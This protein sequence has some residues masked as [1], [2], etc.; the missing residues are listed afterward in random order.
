MWAMGEPSGSHREGDHVHRAALHRPAEQVGEDRLHLGRV[1]PVVGGS[2]IDLVG[3]ADVG[4]VLDPGYVAGIGVRPVAV[5]PLGVAQPGEGAGVDEFLAEPVVLL[6]RAVAPLDAVRRRQGGDLV[7]PGEELGVLGGRGTSI[8]LQSLSQLRPTG[9]AGPVAGGGS[10]GVPMSTSE[11]SRRRVARP[12]ASRSNTTRCPCRSI[13]KIEPARASA[14]RS[15]S[16][17]SVSRITTPAPVSGSYDL[18]TPCKVHLPCYSFKGPWTLPEAVSWRAISRLERLLPPA[19][20]GETWIG[21][22]AA[23]LPG[24]AC[25]WLSIRWSRASISPT[26][27]RVRGGG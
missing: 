23:V 5:R 8:I 3:R 27:S 1:A 6:G 18:T 24:R 19:P 22:D 20:P 21:D 13:R 15:C 25:F 16:A 26:T 12:S 17:R 2:G 10:D 7:D 4:A 14:A 11:P 9:L